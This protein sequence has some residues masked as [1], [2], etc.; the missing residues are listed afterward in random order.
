MPNRM[1]LHEAL[2]QQTDEQSAYVPAMGVVRSVQPENETVK[3]ETYGEPG[4]SASVIRHPYMGTNSW[5]R[6]MPETGTSVITQKIREPAQIEI[7]GYISH[8]LGGMVRDAKEDEHLL[9]RELRQGEIEI[10]SPGYAYQHWSEE[11]NVTINGG[12]V[13]LHLTQTELEARTRAPTH[14][15]QLDQ[16]GPTVLAHE[17]R[18]GLVKRPDTAKPNSLQVYMKAGTD[19]QYEYGRWLQDD[20]GKDLI[21]LHEG[22]LYDAQQ[23]PIKNGQTNRAVRLRRHIAHRKTGDLTF[24]VDEELNIVLQNTSKAKTTDLDFGLKNDI[25]ISSKKLDFNV[26][27]SSNQI[28]GTSFTVRAPKMQLNSPSVGFGAVPVQPAVLGTAL[29]TTVLGPMV[30]LMQAGFSVL[31]ADP[32]LSPTTK[33]TIQNLVTS[34]GSVAGAISTVLSTEVR[35]TK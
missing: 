30:G 16:H 3:I 7:S 9:F 19:Y 4:A 13:E 25:K 26:V 31:L 20:E 15:R 12:I 28:F 6:T 2:E 17:E 23:Q 5:I 14:R 24:D 33:T 21:S 32:A 11:G 18:F 27:Q 34:M 35:F 1:D 8:R 10:M 22:H 29:T